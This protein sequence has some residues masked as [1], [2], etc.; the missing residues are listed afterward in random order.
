MRPVLP[1]RTLCQEW[2]RF[3][4]ETQRRGENA[5]LREEPLGFEQAMPTNPT[6]LVSVAIREV[7]L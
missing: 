6:E 5:E 3:S 2:G 4:T 7:G 1:A